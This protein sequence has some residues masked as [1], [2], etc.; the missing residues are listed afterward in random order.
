MMKHVIMFRAILACGIATMTSIYSAETSGTTNPSPLQATSYILKSD[1]NQGDHHQMLIYIHNQSLATLAI[2]NELD[3]INV[4]QSPD[5]VKS[6]D[7]GDSNNETHYDYGVSGDGKYVSVSPGECLKLML[8][9]NTEQAA[10]IS[11]SKSIRFPIKFKGPL[12]LNQNDSNAVTS[13]MVSSP[14][15]TVVE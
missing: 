12:A 3:S 11:K 2:F 8:L 10:A 7:H 15:W 9:I 1:K 4:K 6:A 5:G 14:V 13:L